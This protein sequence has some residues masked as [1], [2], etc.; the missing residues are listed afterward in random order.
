MS[1]TGIIPT[2]A[3][4]MKPDVNERVPMF[5]LLAGLTAGIV[6]WGYGASWAVC[7][8]VAAVAAAA[9]TGC[10]LAGRTVAEIGR[11]HV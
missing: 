3:T 6:L 7:G 11:A 10:A 9:I 8:A 1:V 5:P 4:E 2:F